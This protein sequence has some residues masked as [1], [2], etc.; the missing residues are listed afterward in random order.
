MRFQNTPPSL[1]VYAPAL[2]AVSFEGAVHI[3]EWDTIYGEHFTIH[4]E[5]AGDLT[6]P[7]EVNYL[8][9]TAEGASQIALH[10]HA[11]HMN[12]TVGGTG[13]VSASHLQT[14]VANIHLMGASGVDISVSD[15]LNVVIEGVG[16]VRYK[17]NPTVSQETGRL[18]S[19]ERV[20]E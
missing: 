17:G 3:Q 2:A 9:L 18:G 14:N 16:S 19:V 10:G 5:G 15:A 12:I 8:D 13:G 1:Y 11:N 7:L 4:V 6:M 20:D